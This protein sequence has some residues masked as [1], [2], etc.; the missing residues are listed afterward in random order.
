MNHRQTFI[1]GG[2]VAQ[3]RNPVSSL[4]GRIIGF[5]V[6]QRLIFSK[7][8]MVKYEN[9]IQKK[10]TKIHQRSEVHSAPNKE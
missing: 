6:K 1:G 3:G 8:P 5:N 10:G 4:L 9:G 2:T 7:T